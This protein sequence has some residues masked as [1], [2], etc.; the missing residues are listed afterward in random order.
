MRNKSKSN[1][2]VSNFFFFKI[3]KKDKSKKMSTIDKELKI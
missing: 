3:K 1:E 2:F